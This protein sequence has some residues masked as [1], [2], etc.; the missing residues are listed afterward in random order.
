[1]R[2]KNVAER[3]TQCYFFTAVG[4]QQATRFDSSRSHLQAVS[5]QGND[6]ALPTVGD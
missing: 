1:M 6:G 5:L 4:L 3:N 2:A